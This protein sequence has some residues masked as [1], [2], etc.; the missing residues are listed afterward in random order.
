MALFPLFLVI[1]G[2]GESSKVAMTAASAFFPMVL[3]AMAGVR[4]ISPAHYEVAQSYGAGRRRVLTAVVLPG[5]LPWVLTGVRLAVNTAMLVAVAIE[6]VSGTNG[7]G[8]RVWF[9]WQTLRTPDLYA[10][11]VVIAVTGIVLNVALDLAR[12]RLVP[13]DTERVR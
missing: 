12:A 10:T 13:W 5:S 11:L 2:I 7:V 6:L 9:A 3:S 8:G 1:F 4:Q